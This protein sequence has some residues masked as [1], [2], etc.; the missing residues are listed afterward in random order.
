MEEF[1]NDPQVELREDLASRGFMI[2]ESAQLIAQNTP[3]GVPVLLSPAF[4][5]SYIG[6]ILLSDPYL[7]RDD[8]VNKVYDAFARDD[9]SLA[10][11]IAPYHELF[12]AFLQSGYTAAM[13]ADL[14][15]NTYVPIDHFYRFGNDYP[16]AVGN[17]GSAGRQFLQDASNLIELLSLATPLPRRF[18]IEVIEGE[19][20]WGA[21]PEHYEAVDQLTENI[22]NFWL[23]HHER[24]IFRFTIDSLSLSSPRLVYATL[25]FTHPTSWW[26]FKEYEDDD[27]D[28]NHYKR[29]DL[30]PFAHQYAAD[31]MIRV[32]DLILEGNPDAV[33]VLQSDHGFHVRDTQTHLLSEGYSEEEVIELQHSVFSAVRIPEQYGGLDAPLDPRNITREL[34]N[35]FVGENYQLLDQ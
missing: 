24:Q 29:V 9:I 16:H 28:E 20:E 1:F 5:D 26:L 13:I 4:Y 33:I 17:A 10:T 27:V 15:S 3:I 8:R 32:I 34:V 31:V 25:M 18:A 6:E 30:Y 21:I 14:D 7:L 11:D 12:H 23:L 2:N 35:R 22:D 19:V